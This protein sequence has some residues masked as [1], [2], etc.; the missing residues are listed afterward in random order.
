MIYAGVDV[1]KD[2]LVTALADRQGEVFGKPQTFP[3]NSVG[4]KRMQKW[5]KNEC[6]GEQS[7][8]LCMEST[9]IYG[10]KLA[11]WF[12]EKEGFTVSII[13]PAQIHAFARAVLKRTKTD[14]VDAELISV[15]A[16]LQK[17]SP[18]QP[19]PE[20]VVKI[21]QLTRRLDALKASLTKETNRLKQLKKR[22]LN[23]KEVLGS[24]KRQVSFLKKEIAELEKSCKDLVNKNPDLKADHE[25][26]TSIPGV[27]DLSSFKL[28]GEMGTCVKSRS[29]KQVVAHSG[30]SPRERSSGS[31]VRGRARISKAGNRFL[32][33]ALYMPA[34]VA[35]R[36]NPV[37]KAFYQRLLEAGKSNKVALVACMKKLLHIVYGVLKNKTKFNPKLHEKCA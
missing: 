34:L 17:P 20:H 37:I 19:E 33:R 11:H 6:K 12:Y 27:G 24:V 13:N 23:C 30:L 22:Q 25:L 4:F 15:F 10:E 7:F 32:R 9:G 5:I 16:A 36:F 26:I 35:I 28:L 21:K 3:N 29:V 14:K 2:E 31:S 18:W 8:H 1:G